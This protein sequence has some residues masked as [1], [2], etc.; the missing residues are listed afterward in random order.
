MSAGAKAK[1]PNTLAEVA[2]VAGHEAAIALSLAYGGEWMHVP[3]AAYL[4]DHPEHRL[5]RWLGARAAA[6]VARRMAGNMIYVPLAH[7]ACARHLAA[8]GE[9]VVAIAARL[10]ISTGSVRRYLRD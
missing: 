10:R 5:V 8:Q 3:A 4:A 2:E 6:A 7:R 1:L 9:P